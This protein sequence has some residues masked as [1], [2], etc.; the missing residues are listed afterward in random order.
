MAQTTGVNLE[1]QGKTAL[2]TGASRG[3]GAAS[4]LAL[5]RAGVQRF[6]LH[7]NGHRAGVDEISGRLKSQGA[8][9]EV[10]QADLSQQ[11]GIEA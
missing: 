9:T 4:A 7:Y 10:L 6:L 5:A 11:S 2:I 1:L 8:A 3:I